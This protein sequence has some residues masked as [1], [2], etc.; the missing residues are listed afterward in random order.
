MFGAPQ[1][2]GE[3]LISHRMAWFTPLLRAMAKAR[4]FV[5]K[6]RKIPVK[7]VEVLKYSAGNDHH[8]PRPQRV[9]FLH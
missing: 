1:A 7:Q 2:G 9:W 6:C 3:R 4:G 5:T 8:S